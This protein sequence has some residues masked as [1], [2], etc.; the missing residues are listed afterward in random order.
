M[1]T[2]TGWMVNFGMINRRQFIILLSLFAG[3]TTL[4]TGPFWIL[5]KGTWDDRGQWVDRFYWKDQS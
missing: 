5:A 3:C 4:V 2:V 1:M